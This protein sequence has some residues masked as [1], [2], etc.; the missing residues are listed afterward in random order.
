MTR[1]KALVLALVLAAVAGGQGV[2]AQISIDGSVATNFTNAIT[3]TIGVGIGLPTFDILAGA[4]IDIG[5]SNYKDDTTP[6][7][8]RSSGSY[9]FGIYAGIAPV[10]ALTEEWT[11]SIPLLARVSFS[12]TKETKWDNSAITVVPGT[13]GGAGD[14]TFGLGLRAGARAAYM[15]SEH[16]SLYTGFLLDVVS[17]SQPR[18]RKWKTTDPKDGTEPVDSATSTFTVLRSGVVQIGVSFWL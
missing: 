18:L 2:F 8:N 3:P 6:L 14:R 4:S 5:A 10:V 7:N 17:W 9:A 15:F 12:G 16:W 13:T 1:R 11:L